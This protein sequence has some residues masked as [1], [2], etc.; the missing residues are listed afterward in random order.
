MRRLMLSL[1]AMSVVGA[2]FATPTASAQQSVNFFVGG[3]VPTPLDSRG[4]ISGGLSNDVLVRDLDFFAFRFDR[5]RPSAP[6]VVAVD[7]RVKWKQTF[8]LIRPGFVV[9]DVDPLQS[10]TLR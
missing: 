9:R 7:D 4:E 8:R 5:E 1:I 6:R 3:F 2:F 10:K